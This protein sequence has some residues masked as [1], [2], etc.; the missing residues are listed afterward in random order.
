MDKPR[1]TE[2][3]RSDQT[4]LDQ[5]SRHEQPDLASGLEVTGRTGKVPPDNKRRRQPRADQDKP[6][7]MGGAGH[8]RGPK[9]R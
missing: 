1:Q 5:D 4:P 3:A 8:G 6:K 2:I 7:S 9:K